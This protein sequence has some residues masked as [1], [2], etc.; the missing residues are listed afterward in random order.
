VH[1]SAYPEYTLHS[2]LLL[3]VQL[4]AQ[5]EL[6]QKLAKRLA[7]EQSL[8]CV[9]HARAFCNNAVKDFL[10]VKS[11]GAIKSWGTDA[12]AGSSKLFFRE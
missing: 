9:W 3:A 10:C 4:A 12:T 1:C 5:G 6:A 11:A 7:S 2:S 8:H